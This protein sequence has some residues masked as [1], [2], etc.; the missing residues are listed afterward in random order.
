[1]R[2][3]VYV[4]KDLEAR[5]VEAAREAGM[6]VTKLIQQFVRERLETRPGR[7][8]KRLTAL[9]GSWEDERASGEI[10]AALRQNRLEARRRKLR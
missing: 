2:L 6:S 3:S 10:V 4:P 5:L 9:A 1:M 8:G 7:L